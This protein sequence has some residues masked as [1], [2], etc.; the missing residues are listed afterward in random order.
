MTAARRLSIATRGFRGTFGKT[1]V[2]ETIDLDEGLVGVSIMDT[3]RLDAVEQIA[4]DT[5]IELVSVDVSSIESLP[6]DQGPIDI[7][8]TSQSINVDLSES[9]V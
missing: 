1:Y 6:G 3:I 8:V 9:N 2:N 4:I 5:Q 7:Q